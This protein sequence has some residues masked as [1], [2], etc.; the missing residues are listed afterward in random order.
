MKMRRISTPLAAASLLLPLLLNSCRQSSGS[1]RV[2]IGG[3]V[4]RVELAVD[5]ATR[6]KGLSCRTQIPQGTGMLFVFPRQEVLRFHMLDCHVPIDIAFISAELVVVD[7]QSMR[8]EP[9]PGNPEVTYVSRLP[10][11]F[12]LEVAGGAL[13]KAG[14]KVGDRVELLGEAAG[15]AKAAR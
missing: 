15:A 12:A 13:E 1:P 10:A 8:V 6:R 2:G 11:R 5:E 4:W 7:V 3:H 9:S 14:V